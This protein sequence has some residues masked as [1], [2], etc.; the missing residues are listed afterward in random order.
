MPKSI[1]QIRLVSTLWGITL[2]K[3]WAH[4]LSNNSHDYCISLKVAAFCRLAQSIFFQI[5]ISFIVFS[6][7][8]FPT[9]QQ[10]ILTI[11]IYDNSDITL[12]ISQAAAA[13]GI[14]SVA[15]KLL[16]YFYFPKTTIK[17][18]VIWP[19]TNNLKYTMSPAYCLDTASPNYYTQS[20]RFSLF[21]FLLFL[22]ILL[23]LLFIF[24]CVF[25]LKTLKKYEVAFIVV[26]IELQH[27][28]RWL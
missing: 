1:W 5:N 8:F 18:C 2:D 16:L 14:F 25:V 15:I 6:T 7:T 27:F 22:K 12:K 13:C 21:Y 28:W 26:K 9:S 19:A 10:I 17:I 24:L 3:W 11:Q 4:L 23:L 20:I